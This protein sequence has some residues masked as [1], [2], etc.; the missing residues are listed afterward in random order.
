[1]HCRK[2]A[3]ARGIREPGQ[4]LTGAAISGVLLC[5]GLFAT[6]ARR[7]AVLTWLGRAESLRTSRFPAVPSTVL[8]SR[9]PRVDDRYVVVARR[10]RPQSFRN[11]LARDRWLTPSPTPSTQ[12]RGTRLSVHRRPRSR[13]DVHG[14]DL[15]QGSELSAGPHRRRPAMHATSANRSPPAAMSMC[16]R[17]TAPATAGIDE[18][19]QLRSNVGVR[20][21]RGRFKVYI[22]DEVHMLTKE[23]FNALLKT[24]EEP[25][26][27]CQIRLLHHRSRKDPDHGL[28]RCQRFDFPPV[29]TGDDPDRL[30]QIAA[31]PKGS[32]PRKKRSACWLAGPM[33]RCETASRCWS[34]CCRSAASGS[35][36]A[37]VHAMLGTAGV[38][39]LHGLLE[40]LATAERR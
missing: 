24:L 40:H 11:W 30:R 3:L 25:P 9:C 35:P 32:R 27:A 5:E 26:A 18:I 19:R 28:S 31:E 20:P 39:R 29:E 37:D 22:I 6:V 36:T 14:A 4:A 7:S 34:N 16:W 38:E 15:R 12:P 23:A 17:S 21:S 8:R 1:M 2:V 13:Q 10:Y 33:D